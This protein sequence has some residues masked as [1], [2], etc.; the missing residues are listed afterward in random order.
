MADQFIGMSVAVIIVTASI[1][2]AGILIGVGRAFGY[3]RLEGF[4]IEE[5]VQSVINAAIIG[6]LASVI[7]LISG[8]STSLVSASCGTGD[9]PAQLSCTLSGVK[10]AMFGMFQEA[11]KAANLLGYYQS[12]SLNFGAFS[13]QPFTNLSAMSN[14]LAGQLFTMQLLLMLLELNIQMLNFVAQNSLM[15]LLPAGLVLRTLFATRKAGGFMIGLAIGLYLFYPALV[16]VFPD[17]S[18][19]LANSTSLMA[20][21]TGNSLYAT[22]PVVDLNGNYAIGGK[23]DLMS[24]RCTANAPNSSAC[25]NVTAGMASGSADFSGDLT[26]VTQSN[27]NSIAKTLLY[28]VVAPLLSLLVTMVFVKEVGQLLGSEIGLTAFSAI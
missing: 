27:S 20:N 8:V 25:S 9:A 10:A 22:V 12:L 5:L 15:L 14:I 19:A 11:V 4:G 2:F 1:A 26:A 17:P 13:I 18:S 6:G 3:R 28:S 24:G 7:A 16:L 21:F 23:L